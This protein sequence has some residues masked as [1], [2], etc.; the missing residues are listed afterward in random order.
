MADAPGEAPT[1]EELTQ[2]K[3]ELEILKLEVDIRKVRVETF[4]Y[5]FVV[6]SGATVAAIAIA[7]LFGGSV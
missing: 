1:V 6:L 3:L 5:P 7:R 2:R 4:L